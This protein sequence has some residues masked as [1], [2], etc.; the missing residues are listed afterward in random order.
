MGLIQSLVATALSPPIWIWEWPRSSR[1]TCHNP[2]V[3]SLFCR[4][5][6]VQA[7]GLMQPLRLQGDGMGS[8]LCRLL[9]G[10]ALGL[11]PGLMQPLR[12]QGD[13]MGSFLCRLL[14]GQ[15]LGLMPGQMQPLGL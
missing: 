15:A 12:L 11:M 7:M 6:S 1:I 14:S 9:S 5:L 2:L 4:L 3:T 10:Q 13:G 8:F